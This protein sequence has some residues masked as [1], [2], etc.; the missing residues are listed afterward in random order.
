MHSSL[1]PIA[2]TREVEVG[3]IF[4]LPPAWGFFDRVWGTRSESSPFPTASAERSG[5]F[6]FRFILQVMCWGQPKFEWSI[7]ARCGW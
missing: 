1:T 7:R 6:R 3:T 4:V 5:E 2:I